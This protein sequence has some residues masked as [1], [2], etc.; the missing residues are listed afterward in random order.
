MVLLRYRTGQPDGPGVAQFKRRHSL[1]V[2]PI[3]RDVLSLFYLV[4]RAH[5]LWL[6]L[7]KWFGGG[8]LAAREQ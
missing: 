7:Q 6:V 2:E 3:P 5:R 8:L 4:A 1:V